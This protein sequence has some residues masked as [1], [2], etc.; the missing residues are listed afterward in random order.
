M[1]AKCPNPNVKLYISEWNLSSI[2]W[3]TGL[4]AGG[5]LNV[6][7]NQPV[8][9]MGAAALF[10]RRTDAPAWNNAF[11]NFDYKGLFVAPNY[12]VTKLWHDHFSKTRLAFTGETGD[13]SISTTLSENGKDV[14]VKIVNP[15]DKSYELTVEGDW[16]SLTNAGYEYIAPGSLDAANSMESPN[17]VSVKKM[18]V[19]PVNKTVTL[20]VAPLSAGVLTLTK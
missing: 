19:T 2:D 13:I 17:A 5:F 7:E 11:I 10:I 12:L 14:F 8:V 4:F 16:K 18:A 20:A 3:R 6:C 9:E 15:T 1:I